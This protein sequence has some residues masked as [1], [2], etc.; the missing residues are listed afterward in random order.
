MKYGAIVLTVAALSVNLAE[1]GTIRFETSDLGIAP[2]G[3]L[4]VE[5]VFQLQD[6]NLGQFQELDIRFNPTYFKSLFGAEAGADFDILLLQPN[7]PPGSFGDFSLLAMVDNPSLDTPLSVRATLNGNGVPAILP[8][9][10]NE[11]DPV[12]LEATKLEAGRSVRI[13]ATPEPGT[14]ATA[15][16]ALLAVGAATR[17]TRV[18]R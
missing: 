11:F 12:T 5:L 15:M 13:G 3:E 4:M 9:F 17:R 1:A 6:I 7:N 16:I 2:T 8:F 14:L 10:I 18:T